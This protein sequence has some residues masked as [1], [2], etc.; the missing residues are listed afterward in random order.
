[1]S[2]TFATD[3]TIFK[4]TSCRICGHGSHCGGP[5]WKEVTDYACERPATPRSIEVCKMCSC[6]NC[7]TKK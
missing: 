5:L 3:I 2:K 1:M 4:P 7:T 6:P